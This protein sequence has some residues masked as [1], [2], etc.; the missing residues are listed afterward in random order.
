MSTQTHEAETRTKHAWQV[1]SGMLPGLI[2]D[3]DRLRAEAMGDQALD[4]KVKE[5]I[6][7]GISVAER[8]ETSIAYHVHNALAAGATREEIAETVG[9]AIFVGTEPA[10][11][12]GIQLLEALARDEV[13]EYARGAFRPPAHP[14]MSPD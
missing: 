11:I 5:L 4:K 8:S 9:V 2:H 12:Q 13:E 10:A 3:L 7:L 1:G 6:A 14:Y